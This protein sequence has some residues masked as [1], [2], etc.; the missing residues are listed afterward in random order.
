MYVLILVFDDNQYEK[1]MIDLG[2]RLLT[3]VYEILSDETMF[4]GVELLR[5]MR[6]ANE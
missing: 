5:A 2:K 1:C 3:L 6:Y 4:Y